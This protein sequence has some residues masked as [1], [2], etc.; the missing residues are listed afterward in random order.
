MSFAPCVA[1]MTSGASEDPPI[2]QSTTWVM[3][4]S[5]STSRSPT[6][7][8]TRDRD[9]SAS[10]TQA[11]RLPASDSASEPQKVASRLAMPEA[12]LSVTSCSTVE[13]NA[14]SSR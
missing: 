11:S 13:E 1:Q 9:S 12:T 6:I 8:S 14:S 4:R 3:P 10:P 2:P 7:S 5:A